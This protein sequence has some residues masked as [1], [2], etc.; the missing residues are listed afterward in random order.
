MMGWKSKSI[1]AWKQTQHGF[2]SASQGAHKQLAAV[3]QDGQD[4]SIWA[5]AVQ[6][7]HATHEVADSEY[8]EMRMHS[9]AY[10][11]EACWLMVEA[12]RART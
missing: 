1:A 6:W 12:Q 4:C 9:G 3:R 7:M 5:S 8:V 2:H 11:G 10:V